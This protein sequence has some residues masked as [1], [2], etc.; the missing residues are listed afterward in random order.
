MLG[1]IFIYH[2]FV[3]FLQIN[4]GITASVHNYIKILYKAKQTKTLIMK[5][6]LY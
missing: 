5:F 6:M 3:I 1:H 4:V 2:Y